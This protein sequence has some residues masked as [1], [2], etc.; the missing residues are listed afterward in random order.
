VKSLATTRALRAGVLGPLRFGV[1]QT[2][3]ETTSDL[4]LFVRPDYK[5]VGK[6]NY[7]EFALWRWATGLGRG[8]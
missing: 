8:Q 5:F 1:A 7:M 2:G 3:N 6:G 4:F